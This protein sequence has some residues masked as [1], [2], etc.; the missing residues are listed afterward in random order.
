VLEGVTKL[1]FTERLL[2]QLIATGEI[3]PGEPLRQLE[4]AE[5]LGVSPTPVRE[6]LRRLEAQ[7]LVVHHPYQGVRVVEVEPEEMSELYIIR[8]SLEGLAVEHATSQI[9]EKELDRLD[10]LH[11]RLIAARTKGAT[12]GLR[13]LNFEFHTGLYRKSGL[14]RLVR[15]VD[16]L[17]PLFPWDSMWAIPGRSESS[18]LEHAQ[19]LI[20]IREGDATGA[21]QAMRN[22]IESGAR[23]LLKFR[24]GACETPEDQP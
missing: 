2:F 24:L 12:K 3:G 7:G 5:K 19:I 22:H 4:L 23:A 13:K 1:D 9:N 18:E 16:S 15:I 21:G 14:P 11:R 10:A 8:A 17:W 20:A 6:A